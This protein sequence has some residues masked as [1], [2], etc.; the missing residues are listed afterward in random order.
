MLAA[1]FTFSDL[2][3]N[4]RSGL[5]QGTVMATPRLFN[6]K[7]QICGYVSASWLLSR[8]VALMFNVISFLHV[9]FDSE[10]SPAPAAAKQ[11]RVMY[12]LCTSLLA[13]CSYLLSCRVAFQ[14]LTCLPL[15]VNTFFSFCI[16][17]H[18]TLT[19]VI[20]KKDITRD[21]II[22]VAFTKMISYCQF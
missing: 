15:D 3:A 22:V 21:V 9:A 20:K 18:L 4:V 17:K 1:L 12:R 2:P 5:D 10:S 11:P 19:K 13:K 16:C 8:E 6:L 7:D 14:Y